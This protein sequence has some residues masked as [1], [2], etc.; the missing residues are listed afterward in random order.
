MGINNARSA[1]SNPDRFRADFEILNRR[2][3]LIAT[4]LELKRWGAWEPCRGGQEYREAEGGGDLGQL[5]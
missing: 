3:I 2:S 4:S 1:S 5:I